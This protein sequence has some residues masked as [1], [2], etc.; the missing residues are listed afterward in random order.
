M[1]PSPSIVAHPIGVDLESFGV[2]GYIES[3]ALPGASIGPVCEAAYDARF[4][5]AGDSP[6]GGP[7]KLVLGD[8]PGRLHSVLAQESGWSRHRRFGTHGGRVDQLC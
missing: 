7:G 2:G 3:Y 4:R 1:S 8:Y 6:G 5:V